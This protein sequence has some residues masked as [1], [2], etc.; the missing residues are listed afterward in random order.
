MIKGRSPLN[1]R[2]YSAVEFPE[3]HF[4]N[5]YL[6]GLG[7]TKDLRVAMRDKLIL[8][9]MHGGGMRESETLHLWVEDV[10]LDSQNPKKV[11][12]RIYHPEDGRAPNGWKSRTGASHRAAY[13]KETYAL[14]PRTQHTNTHHVG[15]KAAV[16]DGEGD[17]LN[18]QW[19]PA[20]YGHIFS[21]LWQD[22]LRLLVGVEKYHPYAFVSFDER[23]KGKPYTLNAFHNNYRQG[24]KRI[25]LTPS[26]DNGLSPHSHRHSYG[27]RLRRAGLQ[28]RVIQ[29]CLHHSS[30]A[31]QSVYTTPTAKEVSDYLDQATV[32]LN[33]CGQPDESRLIPSWNTLL[34]HGFD[35]IDPD[36][37]F[38]GEAPTLEVI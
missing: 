7:C 6:N 27:R 19:F 2:D 24:L 30:I 23:Y 37:L 3:Q 32:N 16:S 36:G 28:E 38:S 29:K 5:L 21:L 4:E 1:K 13:L 31:S 35:D 9:L 14:S 17:Y 11:F 22:Y 12:V 33:S 34:K 18:V 25:G 8:L 10:Y 20:E 15:W 26:K